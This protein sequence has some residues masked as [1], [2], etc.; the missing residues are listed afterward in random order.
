MS[1]DRGNGSFIENRETEN[2][3]SIST[4]IVFIPILLEF[5]GFSLNL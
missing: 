3:Q 2:R 5:L 1:I 4:T